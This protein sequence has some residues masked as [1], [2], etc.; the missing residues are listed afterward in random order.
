ML[1]TPFFLINM[2][3]LW[4]QNGLSQVAIPPLEGGREHDGL[5]VTEDERDY[6]AGQTARR[7]IMRKGRSYVISE[8]RAEAPPD[9][10][11][12]FSSQA[13]GEA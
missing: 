7:L 1:E 5:I 13:S 6:L 4:R 8:R 11:I 10:A 3:K 9:N 2:R 12:L